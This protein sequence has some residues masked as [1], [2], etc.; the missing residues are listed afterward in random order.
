M[1]HHPRTTPRDQ[2]EQPAGAPKEQTISP[3]GI[4]DGG[5]VRGRPGGAHPPLFGVAH[6]GCPRGR[7]ARVADLPTARLEHGP[8][9]YT[10]CAGHRARSPLKKLF[11]CVRAFLERVQSIAIKHLYSP[12]FGPSKHAADLF[13]FPINNHP[14]E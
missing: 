3:A 11:C 4:K 13:P 10:T 2:R 7:L 8:F 12:V 5:T 1:P 14:F 6:Q 9:P